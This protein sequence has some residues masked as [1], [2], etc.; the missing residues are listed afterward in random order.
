M[1][2]R[3]Y[4]HICRELAAAGCA[5]KANLEELKRINGAFSDIRNGPHVS[6]PEE[7]AC[8]SSVLRQPD[9]QAVARQVT[10]VNYAF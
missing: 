2:K 3:N 1:T 4:L 6:Q 10:G 7:M 8:A 5:L 9:P